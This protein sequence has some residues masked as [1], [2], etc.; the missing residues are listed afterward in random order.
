MLSTWATARATTG[1]QYQIQMRAIRGYMR[2]NWTTQSGETSGSLQNLMTL[3][4]GQQRLLAA[5]MAMLSAI[6]TLAIFATG[7]FSGFAS[8]CG[9]FGQYRCTF[10][11]VTAPGADSKSRGHKSSDVRSSGRLPKRSAKFMILPR[12]SECTMSPTP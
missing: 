5:L 2:T 1:W 9:C 6:A 3:S 7:A 10:N 11:A 12:K 8:G 4:A